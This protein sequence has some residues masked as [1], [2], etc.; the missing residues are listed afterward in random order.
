VSSGVFKRPRRYFKSKDGNLWFSE[1]RR[2]HHFKWG[3]WQAGYDRGSKRHQTDIFRCGR[4]EAGLCRWDREPG[5]FWYCLHDPCRRREHPCYRSDP[6][7]AHGT[8]CTGSDGCRQG[9]GT[10]HA[11]DQSRHRGTGAGWRKIPYH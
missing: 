3:R 2:L 4:T 1:R 5:A 10:D 7:M 6:G 11:G 9:T 8:Q